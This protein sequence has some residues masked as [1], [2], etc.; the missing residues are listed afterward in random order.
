MLPSGV[1]GRPETPVFV[2]LGLHKSHHGPKAIARSAPSV[3]SPGIDDL[4]AFE[5][6]ESFLEVGQAGA[7]FRV[8]GFFRLEFLVRARTGM[9]AEAILYASMLEVYL[10]VGSSTPPSGQITPLAT[11][12]GA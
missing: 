12:M 7:Q 5:C 9:A 4:L 1:S 10:A 2:L 8:F 11:W 3:R 6:R